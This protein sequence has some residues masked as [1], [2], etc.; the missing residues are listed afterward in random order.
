MVAPR[1]RPDK[2][3]PIWKGVFSEENYNKVL[4]LLHRVQTA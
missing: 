1:L 3:M 2:G 4:A